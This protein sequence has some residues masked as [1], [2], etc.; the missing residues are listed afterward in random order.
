MPSNWKCQEII[1]CNEISWKLEQRHIKGR[2]RS[3]TVII[4]QCK[5]CIY[6]ATV[7][8]CITCA[9]LTN[10]AAVFFPLLLLFSLLHWNCFDIKSTKNI[11]KNYMHTIKI[12]NNFR[13]YSLLQLKLLPSIF[14]IPSFSMP[15]KVIMFLLLPAMLYVRNSRSSE[16][17]FL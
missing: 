16:Y 11:E 9:C 3:I 13:W 10:I 7:P 4:I 14:L 17:N 6:A 8:Q 2:D 15:C 1:R 5:C 12:E